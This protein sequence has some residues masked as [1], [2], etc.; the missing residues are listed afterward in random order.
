MSNREDIIEG[1]QATG[2]R[3]RLVYTKQ[4]G[5]VDLGHARP[6]GAN[7]LWQDINIQN[8]GVGN[9]NHK[10]EYSQWMRKGGIGG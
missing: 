4:C 10:L 3:K 6:D 9:E 5:W 7:G 1:N 8:H 2:S